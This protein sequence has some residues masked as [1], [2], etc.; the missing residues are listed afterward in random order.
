MIDAADATTK[1]ETQ[2]GDKNIKGRS[3]SQPDNELGAGERAKLNG[4]HPKHALDRAKPRENGAPAPEA[5]A[6]TRRATFR[7]VPASDMELREPEYLVDGLIETNTLT[8]LFGEPGAGKSFLAIDIAA[9][10]ATGTDFHGRRVKSGAA[11]YIAGEGH[12]GLRRRTR[13]W[14]IQQ[15]AT[16]EGAPLFFSETAAQL[17]DPAHFQTVV[18][19]IS[20][21]TRT[22]GG[23]TLIIVDTLAR[24]FGAGDENAT[25][26]MNRFV[27]AMDDFRTQ[28]PGCTVI[29]V[30]HTGQT[31]RSRARGSNALK[32][33]SDAEF[34]ISLKGKVVLMTCLRR[35][36]GPIAEALAFSLK[37]IEV[38]AHED[39]APFTSAALEA[40][41]SEEKM[42]STKLSP[43]NRF[44]LNVLRRAIKTKGDSTFDS[45]GIEIEAWQ[46]AF[47]EVRREK[48]DAANR[49]A[50]TRAFEVLQKL[51]VISLSGNVV[52]LAAGTVA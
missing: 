20:R 28:F 3:A 18:E 8:V 38:D 17:L 40:T 2:P 49:M 45:T 37:E 42:T 32:A 48:S 31:E 50:F 43:T 16:V 11:V 29:V 25:S 35:K 21:V 34:R 33:A 13:A 27:A 7:L 30:H 4:Q 39:E 24:N 41:G 22:Q 5:K 47:N 46:Q 44:A 26:D 10:V 23:P 14:E 51:N 1:S 9:S 12:S 36:D 19:E 15:N 52:N 6:N